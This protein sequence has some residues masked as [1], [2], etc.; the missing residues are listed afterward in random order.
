MMRSN[1]AITAA[2]AALAL[3]AFA[4]TPA[5]AQIK[6]SEPASVSQTIDGTTFTIDYSR[7]RVRGR[8]DVFGKE[9]IFDE[10]WTPGANLNTTLR[11]TK[12][13]TLNGHPI[14]AGKYSVWLQVKE[15]G[16]WIM[17]LHGDTARQHFMH[18]KVESGK[19]SFPVT[20][21]QGPST[22]VLTWSFPEVTPHGATLEMDWSTTRVPFTIR[23]TPSQKLTMTAE[24]AAPYLGV[25]DIEWL[26]NKNKPEKQTMSVHYNAA[27]ST[28]V[29]DTKMDND[30]TSFALAP[31]SPGAFSLVFMMEGEIAESEGSL[32]MEFT[33]DNGRMTF[34]M[35]DRKSDELQG[36]GTRKP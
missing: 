32:L 5:R 36:R 33:A 3:S 29:A 21:V 35:R 26:W 11:A 4:T 30:P 25:Y 13:F 23:V 28:L 1:P 10:V 12:D 34:Q 14:P 27:D 8:K 9:V 17:V 16:D 24:E 18:P 2:G 31:V 15:K 6:A 19:F 7:P 22:E 20:P